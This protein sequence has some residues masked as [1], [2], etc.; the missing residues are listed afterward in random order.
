MSSTGERMADFGEVMLRLRAG[1]AWKAAQTHRSLSRFLIEETYETIDAI[2]SGDSAHLCEEL[3]DVLLQ[4]YFH[5]VIA[6]E[7][8]DF[9]LDDVVAGVTAKLIRRNPHVFGHRG[10]GA[11]GSAEADEPMDA[12]AVNEAWERIKASEKTRTTV[13]DGIPRDLPALLYAE[14]VLARLERAAGTAELG[15]LDSSEVDSVASDVQQAGIGN[16]LLRVVDEARRAGVDPEQALREVV[17]ERV[18]R[19]E[20]APPP[21]QTGST[22]RDQTKP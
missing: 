16:R 11:A 15:A 18:R 19:Y 2:D 10:A 5:A 3:G 13:L 14:K 1:C 8:G 20:A 17:K 21:D 22:V 7:R 4:V 9:T 12:S 6:A